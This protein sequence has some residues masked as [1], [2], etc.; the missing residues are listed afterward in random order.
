MGQLGPK[1][2][3]AAKMKEGSV[4]ILPRGICEEFRLILHNLLLLFF[5]ALPFDPLELFRWVIGSND[6]APNMILFAFKTST[7]W[8]QHQEPP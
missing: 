5:S 1:G 7:L 2:S 4:L 3:L 8:N 6:F